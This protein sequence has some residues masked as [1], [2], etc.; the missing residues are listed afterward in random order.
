MVVPSSPLHQKP[1]LG[2]DLQGGLEI[3]KQAVPPKGRK[4][5]KEDLDRSVSIMRDR[6]DRLGVSEPEIRTQGKRPDHDPAAGR[7]GSRGRR[8]DHRQDGPARALRPRGEP[9]AAVDRRA[10][11]NPSPRA[12]STTCSPASRRSP[13]RERPTQYWLFNK[14]KKLVVGPVAT[15]DGGARASSAARCPTG[16][17]LFAV[18][19]GTVVVSCGIG[20]VVCPGVQRRTRRRTRTTCSSTT[21]P[22]VPEMTGSDLKLSGTRQDFDTQTQRSRS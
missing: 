16:Y 5:T 8:E 15:K 11:G 3:T 14:Q 4:L 2:L 13:R 21:P 7:Q 1:T 12:P 17:K 9:R 20:E 6:V 22:D 18:P 19:P 10:A